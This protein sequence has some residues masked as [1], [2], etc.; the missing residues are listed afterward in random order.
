MKRS[1]SEVCNRRLKSSVFLH[2]MNTKCSHGHDKV[3]ANIIQ[4]KKLIIFFS[5]VFKF[6]IY[7]FYHIL[8]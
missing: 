8:R 6:K 7:R 1:I 4:L 2:P 5:M 3:C